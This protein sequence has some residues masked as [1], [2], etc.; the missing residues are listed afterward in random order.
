MAECTRCP[1]TAAPPHEWRCGECGA[2]LRTPIARPSRA[3]LGAGA[4]GLVRYHRWLDSATIVSLGEPE[5]PLLAV[6]WQ[7]TRVRMKF[8]GALP[9]GSFKDRGTAVL[10]G[11]LRAR[12]VRRI[13]EDS[14]G[15]AGASFA[16]YAAACGIDLELFVP[17]SA[18]PAKLAQAVGHGAN[19]RAIEG[20]RQAATDAAVAFALEHDLVYASHQWQPAFNLGTQTFAFELWEQLGEHVPDAVV[21]P[22]GAGGMLLGVHLGF[23]A[24]RD[25]GLTQREPRILA[26][27]SEACAPLAH[28]FAQGL[29]GPATIE[30]GQS[31]AEGV[32]LS[33]PPRASEIL[34]AVRASGGTIVAV[35]DDALWSAHERLRERGLLVETTSALAPAALGPLLEKGL[36]DQN[37]SIVVA[38]TGH[39]LKTVQSVV[40]RLED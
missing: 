5:T 29:D 20:P 15:N 14:S 26:V 39:G 6:D 31:A 23:R 38:A 1:A 17:A 27:Q 36:L 33:S 24:L 35:D 9:S 13:V 18:S 28:A 32:L 34:T 7:G 19:L 37:E 30:R 3:S 21:C 4:R 40:A 10:L 25:A 11:A 8:E 16:A 22:V 2:P 12:G